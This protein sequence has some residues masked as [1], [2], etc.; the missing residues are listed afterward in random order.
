MP[1][2]YSLVFE[3]IIGAPSL[4]SNIQYKTNCATDMAS[5]ATGDQ[6][7]EPISHKDLEIRQKKD[8]GERKPSDIMVETYIHPGDESWAER[9]SAS[10]MRKSSSKSKE[11][12][13]SYKD[14]EIDRRRSKESTPAGASACSKESTPSECS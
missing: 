12:T 9:A 7:K 3:T 8:R 6:D 1:Q 13:P 4:G 2:I 14:S 11:S 10:L 5:A